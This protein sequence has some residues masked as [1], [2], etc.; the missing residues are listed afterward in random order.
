MLCINGDVYN[1]IITQIP[2][3]AIQLLYSWGFVN[4]TKSN[5]TNGLLI[6]EVGQMSRKFSTCML[7]INGGIYTQ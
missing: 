1:I 6:V 4:E 7:C 5:F 3:P 2:A